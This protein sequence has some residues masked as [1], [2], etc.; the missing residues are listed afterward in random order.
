MNLVND[1]TLLKLFVEHSPAAIAMFD[2]EMR[3]LLVSRR[4]LTDRGFEHQDLVGRS[5][6][7]FGCG[8][9]E[10]DSLRLKRC[11]AGSSETWEVHEPNENGVME[12]MKWEVSPWIDSQGEIGGVMMMRS[13]LPF[14]NAEG[15]CS[16]AA[17]SPDAEV[18]IATSTFV[19]NTSFE[20]RLRTVIQSAPITLFVLDCQGKITL[21]EG[22]ATEALG[23]EA[24]ATV[25]HS[26]FE[27][28]QHFPLML[29]DVHSAMA[30]EALTSLME[31]GELTFKIHYSPL[32]GFDNGVTEVIVVAT[33][34]SERRQAEEALRES[35]ILR[36][37]EA[38]N[39]ALLN[40]IPDAIF[41]LHRDGTYLEMRT[42]AKKELFAPLSQQIGENIYDILPKDVAEQQMHYVHQALQTGETQIF[43]YGLVVEG[44]QHDY[45]ARLVM[46][47]QDEVLAIVRDITERKKVERLKNEFVSIVSH[48]LRTPLTSVQ[49]SLSLIAG[50][51]GG[52]I[53]P[54]AKA[55]VDIAYKN[56]ERLILLINDI[57]D[58]EKIKSGQMDFHLN[59]LEVVP[60]VEQAIEVNRAY[61]EQFGV[62]L[63]VEPA[64]NE[65]K[66]NVD[67]DRLMQ[68]LTN[69]LSN[70]IKFSPS[71]ETVTICVSRYGEWGNQ[72][73]MSLPPKNQD[74]ALS[75]PFI[76]IA[77][78]DN[79]SGIPA[80][81]Q[82][83]I[84]EKFA[85]A[86][87]SDT[88]RQ[89]GTGLGLS[90]CK[91]IID[92]LGGHI[93]FESRING[94]TTFYFDLPEW[95]V[96]AHSPLP[97]SAISPSPRISVQPRILV[98]EDDPDIATLLSLILQ[99]GD[100][101]TD[102][103]YDAAQAKQLLTKNR[104]AAMTVD[105]ALPDQSGISLVRELREQEST[106]RLPIIVV[107]AKAQQGREE[108]RGG[109]FAVIDWLDKPIDQERLMAAVRQAFITPAGR[110]PQILHV[111]DDPDLT[112]VIF[113][114]LS[115]LVEIDTAANLQEAKQKLQ[116]K[117]FDLVI[118]DLSLP[119]GSGLELLP[120]L[121]SQSQFPIPVL[122]FSAK[123][124][125]MESANQ[126][127]AALVKSRTSNQQLLDTI[128]SLIDS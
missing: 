14:R 9:L 86:D 89:A 121:N 64:S 45:E 74:S 37:S 76:R 87:A 54:E 4:W 40:A 68:V 88:R 2:R 49:G 57:L 110:K 5:Y 6:Y 28:C 66:V 20:E 69:L 63:L 82:S 67:R 124:V 100:F 62:K 119:D 118:L 53:P 17:R 114:I 29:D 123:E 78:L 12:W 102:I 31:I 115:N 95:K 30:G 1:S 43:E 73:T 65:L 112:Q 125:S 111:E 122:V 127:A 32:C 85:Q 23:L 96:A 21:L 91:A 25:G 42:D 11:L 101:A 107:S 94:G 47:G 51:V 80:E 109:G 77:I 84:F 120:Y 75:C 58:I 70:A 16:S 24:D 56:S 15:E 108:L 92:K 36:Q 50:G 105:L 59:P 48:E 113:A 116:Q 83:Q 52:V 26:V 19:S 35:A 34:I 18:A 104:Y 103:A 128:R 90:I 13:P 3:Y 38:K 39:L 22:T 93:G 27:V 7:E 97:I 41:R 106:Q 60:L 10:Q 72:E 71:N 8:D 79:G 55:L 126:V 81:F 33:D 61:A 99:Q 117:S 44:E 46:N 98:C